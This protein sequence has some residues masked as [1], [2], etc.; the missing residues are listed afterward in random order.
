MG[1]RSQCPEWLQSGTQMMILYR[2]YLGLKSNL[3]TGIT[4]NTELEL[5]WKPRY[6]GDR[7]IK[8]ELNCAKLIEIS[9]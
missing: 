8:I 7:H 4:L 9:K 1:S 6:G 3:C 5:A 2:T